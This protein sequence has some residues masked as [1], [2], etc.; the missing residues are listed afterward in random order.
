MNSHKQKIID[1]R[2]ISGRRAEL[3]ESENET[4]N[5]LIK[6]AH[7]RYA[8]FIESGK[9]CH[10]FNH[11]VKWH[12]TDKEIKK[13]FE[14]LETQHTVNYERG[15]AG[16]PPVEEEVSLEKKINNY[17]ALGWMLKGNIVAGTNNK[18]VQTIVMYEKNNE[19]NYEKNYENN[20]GKNNLLMPP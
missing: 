5:A 14:D 18:W 17:L 3:L 13:I 10:S 7:S 4:K 19:K 6:I 12:N 20:Y 1:I 8:T 15:L 16:L 11:W 9:S 2:F